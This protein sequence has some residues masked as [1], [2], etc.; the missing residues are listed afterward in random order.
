[1]SPEGKIE[2]AEAASSSAFITVGSEST[3]NLPRGVSSLQFSYDSSFL[4]TVDQ[5]RPNIV[6]IW[7]LSTPPILETALVHEH[8]VKTL[9]WHPRTQEL[10]IT[11]VNSTLA[12]THLWSKERTPVVV[13]IPITRNEMGRYDAAWVKS[14]TQEE[15]NVFWFS[16]TEEAVLGHVIY[17][18]QNGDLGR[19]SFNTV[20]VASRGSTVPM[21]AQ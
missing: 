7:A 16:N 14:S 11:T 15:S 1:M 18:D 17:D 8:N 4:A 9:S 21:M 19:A 12:M 20:H 6:W 10:L 2:Y 3:S 5:S 13:E